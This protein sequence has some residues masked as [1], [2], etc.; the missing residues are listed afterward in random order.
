MLK[1]NSKIFL[2]LAFI[3]F[4]LIA[5][6]MILSP[7]QK[8][9]GGKGM[10]PTITTI[11]TPEITRHLVPSVT[12]SIVIEATKTGGMTEKIPEE[13]VNKVEQERNLRKK[14]PLKETGFSIDFNYANDIFIVNLVEPKDKNR[15]VFVNW[16]KNNYPLISIER[17]KLN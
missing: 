14:I 16:L 6:T 10:A 7:G 17:F 11:P 5:T 12:S 2:L 1:L 15:I 13:V 9:L 3:L 4:I 8:D